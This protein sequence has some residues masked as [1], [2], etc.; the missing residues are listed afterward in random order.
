MSLPHNVKTLI[1]AQAHLAHQ[2]HNGSVRSGIGHANRT[3]RAVA[4]KAADEPGAAESRAVD[5][6]LRLP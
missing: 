3:L 5:K 1:K 4:I 6:V 2:K